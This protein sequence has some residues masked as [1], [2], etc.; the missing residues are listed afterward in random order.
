[1]AVIYD[2]ARNG[3][4][5]NMDASGEA[6]YLIRD[7]ANWIPL[8][9]RPYEGYCKY[10]HLDDVGLAYYGLP[11]VEAGEGP[12]GRNF[13][14][15]IQNA[16]IRKARTIQNAD[17]WLRF[18]T[19][20]DVWSDLYAPCG[21]RPMTQAEVI[22]GYFRGQ[23][24][25]QSIRESLA[26]L[27]AAAGLPGFDWT[28]YQVQGMHYD[29]ITHPA[30][31]M[32]V[33]THSQPFSNL[34]W[35]PVRFAAE[36]T[37]NPVLLEAAKNLGPGT[38]WYT[39]H[40]EIGNQIDDARDKARIK[41][42][43]MAAAL[44]ATMGYLSTAYAAGAGSGAAA[45]SGATAGS[46]ASVSGAEL[47]ALVESGTVGAEGAFLEAA[48]LSGA[49]VTYDTA[50]GAILN[51]VLPSGATIAFDPAVD[52]FTQFGLDATSDALTSAV[53]EIGSEIGGE[54]A[55]LGQ[56]E[57]ERAIKTEIAEAVI[58]EA[59]SAGTGTSSGGAAPGYYDYYQ[60]Y[61]PGGPSEYQ[62]EPGGL[63][64]GTVSATLS[65]AAKPLALG[66]G[67]AMLA[68]FVLGDD[69]RK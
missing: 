2:P 47:A 4:Y 19:S 42:F 20:N 66:A 49:S 50:T 45:G 51:A 32:D 16:N 3:W 34:I 68:L 48:S 56:Q 12:S 53:K 26:E 25:E 40:A 41:K 54:L 61:E 58:G 7:R 31:P 24:G 64:P 36:A 9:P 23:N 35:H 11:P 29:F 52:A 22:Y 57:I 17:E 46:T 37:G 39:A 13:A 28:P 10:Q 14:S 43:V 60:P 21:I 69:E 8:D 5:S 33:F 55:Q 30:N 18:M 63:Q 38:E 1:M 27:A 65:R 59:P 67:L 15:E 6:S 62:L 44:I